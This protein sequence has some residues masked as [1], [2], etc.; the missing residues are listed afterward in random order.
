[1]HFKSSSLRVWQ[2]AFFKTRHVF[3]LPTSTVFNLEINRSI[4]V[5]TSSL[6]NSHCLTCC[7]SLKNF[8]IFLLTSSKVSLKK[9]QISIALRVFS[10]AS[11][12]SDLKISPGSRYVRAYKQ[13]RKV[14]KINKLVTCVLCFIGFNQAQFQQ[15]ELHYKFKIWFKCPTVPC[16]IFT[17]LAKLKSALE[18]FFNKP[19]L[20]S[21]F[22]ILITDSAENSS[23]QVTQ[24]ITVFNMV[25]PPRGIQI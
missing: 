15:L 23:N 12:A 16:K 17:S 14:K 21:K 9:E 19:L 11:S 8:W 5:N 3:S 1:M 13:I 4:L 24:Q 6:A 2:A 20:F 22:I 18:H 7:S 10:Y 25:S